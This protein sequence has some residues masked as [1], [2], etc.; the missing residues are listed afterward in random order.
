MTRIPLGERSRAVLRPA[1]YVRQLE[2]R[3]ADV[4]SRGPYR[5]RRPL[6]EDAE[7][8]CADELWRL[9]DPRVVEKAA[10][11]R[12]RAMPWGYVPTSPFSSTR[13]CEFEGIKIRCV[14]GRPYPIA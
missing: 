3:P 12:D 6:I 8:L 1:W 14:R 2:K 13:D 11:G 9:A 10:D 4:C 7:R 5:G